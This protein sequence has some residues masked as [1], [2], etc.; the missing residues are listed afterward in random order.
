MSERR[1]DPAKI[2]KLDNPRRRTEL[3]PE[4]VLDL[5]EVEKTDVVL[6]LGA[7]TGYFT[8]PVASLTLGKVYALDVEHQMLEVL[9]QK[10]NEHQLTNVQL[11]EGE[12][13]EIPMENN[14]V[15]KVIVS[16]VLHEVKFL[17]KG[18]Q[19]IRRVLRQGG[20]CLCLEWEKK[21]MEQGPPLDHRIHSEDMKKAFKEYGFKI[22]DFTYPTE[23]HYII[24]GQKKS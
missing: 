20:R 23:Q 11:M 22:V 19:E 9:K 21:P 15:D 8:L 12:I 1:F 2:Y 17:S 24:I 3:P 18:L 5:L 7:G 14:Q 16:M 13:E 10:V 6:D 4:K